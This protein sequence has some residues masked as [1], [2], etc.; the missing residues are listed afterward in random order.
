MSNKEPKE[1]HYGD[2]HFYADDTR[3][4]RNKNFFNK[5]FFTVYTPSHR[6]QDI[7]KGRRTFIKIISALCTI[8]FIVSICII[9]A[10]MTGLFV[11]IM[12]QLSRNF[13]NIL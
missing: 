10:T 7:H 2:A 3:F 8:A 12:E 1:P 11:L 4:K 13:G 9:L 5:D 6:H